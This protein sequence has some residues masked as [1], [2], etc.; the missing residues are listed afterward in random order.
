MSAVTLTY[1]TTTIVLRSPEFDNVQSI[2]LDRVSRKTRNGDL[3]IF[4]DPNWVKNETFKLP[5][6]Y[7]SQKQIFDLL[8]FIQISLGQNVTLL[9]HEGRTFTG[10]IT[11]PAASIAQ[12]GV[13]NFTVEL[14]F[15]LNQQDINTYGS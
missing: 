2:S 10:T 9:D 13:T 11:T 14:E 8:N 12:P 3:I 6:I 4:R 1:G 5:F 15:Q 7:L